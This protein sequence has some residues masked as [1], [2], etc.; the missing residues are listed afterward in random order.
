L[1]DAAEAIQQVEKLVQQRTSPLFLPL[2]SSAVNALDA[3]RQQVLASG[4]TDL[5]LRCHALML[6]T[7]H[8]VSKLLLLSPSVAAPLRASPLSV[9]PPNTV[10]VVDVRKEG[11]DSAKEQAD[12]AELLGLFMKLIGAP[13]L[14]SPLLTSHDSDD[15]AA[16][17]VPD[18]LPACLPYDVQTWHR[19]LALISHPS[20]GS[21]PPLSSPLL[22]SL[23]FYTSSLLSHGFTPSAH[24]LT[25]LFRASLGSRDLDATYGLL[26]F[27]AAKGLKISDALSSTAMQITDEHTAQVRRE[28]RV[29]GSY[30]GRTVRNRR[31]TRRQRQTNF[32]A[33][34]SQIGGK[35]AEGRTGM[36]VSDARTDP[37]DAAAVRVGSHV[38]GLQA[39]TIKQL[40]QKLMAHHNNKSMDNDSRDAGIL[41]PDASL[42]RGNVTIRMKLD[43]VPGFIGISTINRSEYPK[44]GAFATPQTAAS[45]AQ[46]NPVAVRARP[47][48]PLPRAD[49]WRRTRPKV[50]PHRRRF[51]SSAGAGSQATTDDFMDTSSGSDSDGEWESDEVDT[52]PVTAGMSSEMSE[53]DSGESGSEEEDDEDAVVEMSREDE[54]AIERLTQEAQQ[55]RRMLITSI[56]E[57]TNDPLAI[58]AASTATIQDQ[59]ALVDITNTGAAQRSL[60]GSQHLA[61]RRQMRARQPFPSRHNPSVSPSDARHTSQRRPPAPPSL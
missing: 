48:W 28:S 15:L 38:L 56:S 35:L 12:G 19:A 1:D 21:S 4:A 36:S 17:P 31:L 6:Q 43:R 49:R 14:S 44:D 20:T 27:A 11:P 39:N 45:A 22:S 58:A 13:P 32:P 25:I 3:A 41:K 5:R 16:H 29:H 54:A 40:Q 2:L 26:A 7:C 53:E 46:S 51:P 50:L 10:D 47:S 52:A 24:T 60:N 37:E 33:D 59:A 61:R 30:G 23:H 42:Q 57:M 18:K 34:V 55:V 8:L 9:C